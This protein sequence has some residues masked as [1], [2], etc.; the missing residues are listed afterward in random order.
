M[1]KDAYIS[2]VSYIPF[3]E[4]VENLLRTIREHVFDKKKQFVHT[5]LCRKREGDRYEAG[6]KQV[7]DTFEGSMCIRQA[8]AI[9]SSCFWRH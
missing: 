6:L 9:A 7:R 2:H 3:E 4:F 8:E 1:N 5:N